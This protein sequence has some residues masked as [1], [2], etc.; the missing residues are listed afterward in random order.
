MTSTI[1]P[2][3]PSSAPAETAAV[4]LKPCFCRYRMLTA[5]RPA[6]LGTVRFTNLMPDSSATVGAYGIGLG[7]APVSDSA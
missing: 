2:A 1:V 3:T 7:T 6:E 5:M 4:E